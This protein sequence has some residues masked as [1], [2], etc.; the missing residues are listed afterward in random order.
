MVLLSFF[1]L[2]FSV[3]PEQKLNFMSQLSL[4]NGGS[5][6]TQTQAPSSTPTRPAWSRPLESS[7]KGFSGQWVKDK[8]RFMIFLPNDIYAEGSIQLRPDG[9]AA[10][11]KLL[12]SLQPHRTNIQLTFVG[13]AD[14]V[15]FVRASQNWVRDNFD[16]SSLRA[17]RAL[18]IA[19]RAGFSSDQLYS[20]GK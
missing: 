15:P 11:K 16:L 2:F 1:I 13:H 3:A 6:V 17:T 19:M 9:D 10:L 7:L 4:N 14:P 20:M 18:Q 5:P 12:S 8:N